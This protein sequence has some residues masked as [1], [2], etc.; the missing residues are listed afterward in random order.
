DAGEVYEITQT[1]FNS[2]G[3]DG[4]Q[5]IG[6]ITVP[7]GADLGQTRMR[8]KKIFG[9]TNYLDPCLGTGYG[10][11]ED[12]TI[13]VIIAPPSCDAPTALTLDA[14]TDTTADISWTASPDE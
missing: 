4:Q 12:Y 8:V 3:I 7:I 9:T 14:V 10:Q 1:I 6:S 13:N 11:I 2:T 5:A